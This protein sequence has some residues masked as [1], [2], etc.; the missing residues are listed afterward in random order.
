MKNFNKEDIIKFCNKINMPK[1]ILNK[2][3]DKFHLIAEDKVN[4]FYKDFFELDKAQSAYEN[5][6]TYTDNLDEDNICELT[7]LLAISIECYEK[8]IE[9]N[10]DEKIYIDTMKCFSRFV[11]ENYKWTGKWSF[12]RGFWVWRQLSLSLF[13]I[14]ELEFEICYIDDDTA[15]KLNGYKN[16]K[17]IYVHIPSDA[18]CKIDNLHLSYEQAKQFF[19]TH[20]NAEYKILCSSWLLG[21]ELEDLLCE[22]SGIK[23]FRKDYNI[24][25]SYLESDDYLQWVFNKFDGNIQDFIPKTSLQKA[26]RQHLINGGKMTIGFGILKI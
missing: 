17:V 8:Y 18:N 22:N 23:N 6:K 15:K 19:K 10:I 25:E 21:K 9:K 3:I 20:F 11:L 7:V 13:R 14:G 1:E 2:I 4:I 26:I 16:E 5:L 24:F 12:D